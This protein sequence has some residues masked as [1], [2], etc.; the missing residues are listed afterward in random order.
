MLKYWRNG[1][2]RSS[3]GVTLLFSYV[4]LIPV[5]PAAVIGALFVLTHKERRRTSRTILDQE[6]WHL[7]ISAPIPFTSLLLVVGLFGSQVDKSSIKV[8][9]VYRLG[10]LG[11]LLD[12]KSNAGACLYLLAK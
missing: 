11:T 1:K 8:I 4:W 12:V 5:I 9:K 7:F 6:Y 3:S 10:L 2:V